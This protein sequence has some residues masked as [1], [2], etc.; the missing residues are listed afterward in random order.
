MRS[1]N[2]RCFFLC[3]TLPHPALFGNLNFP[4]VKKKLICINNQ[5]HKRLIIQKWAWTLTRKFR[6]LLRDQQSIR[7]QEYQLNL[8]IKI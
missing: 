4:L 6:V 2:Y 3:N 8:K 5:F 7:K 1:I